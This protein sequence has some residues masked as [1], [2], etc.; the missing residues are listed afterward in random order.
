MAPGALVAAL[1]AILALVSGCAGLHFNRPGRTA[2]CAEALPVA[3]SAVHARGQL[4]GFRVINGR[5]LRTIYLALTPPAQRRPPRLRHLH[6]GGAHRRATPARGQPRPANPN[7]KACL[8]VFKGNYTTSD[9]NGAPPSDRGR[10]AVLV[11]FVRHAGLVRAR[12]IDKL[13]T[14]V[15]KLL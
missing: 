2:A 6:V 5:Q 4:V 9:V 12:L 13:P 8:A 14:A 11:I 3:Y 7:R 15:K 1:A 10:Y